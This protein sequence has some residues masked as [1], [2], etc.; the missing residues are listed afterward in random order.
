MSGAQAVLVAGVKLEDEATSNNRELKR[1]NNGIS[2][3]ERGV[4]VGSE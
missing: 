4:D 2:R 3:V 1:G